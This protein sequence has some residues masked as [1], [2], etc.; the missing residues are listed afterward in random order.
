[1]IQ[2]LLNP[3]AYHQFAGLRAKT[4]RASHCRCPHQSKAPAAP[5]RPSGIH[6]LYKSVFSDHCKSAGVPLKERHQGWEAQYWSGEISPQ[7]FGDIWLCPAF[8]NCVCSHFTRKPQYSL[9]RTATQFYNLSLAPIHSVFLSLPNTMRFT[10][11]SSQSTP[12]ALLNHVHTL[13][14]SSLFPF[15]STI[16][17][18]AISSTRFLLF[19]SCS[20]PR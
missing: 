5:E 6:C 4:P 3:I 12:V 2:S 15:S 20:H 14:T 1:M 17:R 10:S 8:H 18:P 16:T 13:L 7:P 11:L 9:A 19:S